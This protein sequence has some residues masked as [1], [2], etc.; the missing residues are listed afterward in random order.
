MVTAALVIVVVGQKRNN[1]Y[2]FVEIRRKVVLGMDFE[3]RV[4]FL[5]MNM[6]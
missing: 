5:Y 2:L 3:E 6:G 4:G 1:L